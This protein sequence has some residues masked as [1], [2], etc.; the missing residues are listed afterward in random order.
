MS[1]V[2]L[3]LLSAALRNLCLLH[4]ENTLHPVRW[5][6]LPNRAFALFFGLEPQSALG[7]RTLPQTPAPVMVQT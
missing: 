1:L 5:P 6:S 4:R 2:T 7:A 3:D